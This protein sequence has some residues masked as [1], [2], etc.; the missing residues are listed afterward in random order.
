MGI[1]RP[2]CTPRWF[3][4][5]RTGW[6]CRCRGMH[7][8]GPPAMRQAALPLTWPARWAGL[9]A[10][11]WAYTQAGPGGSRARLEW[12]DTRTGG[13][14][15]GHTRWRA[16]G[17][18]YLIVAAV[19]LLAGTIETL[20]TPARTPLSLADLL[21]G[22][23]LHLLLTL[24][25]TALLRLLFWRAHPLRFIALAFGGALLLELGVVL[26]YWLNLVLGVPPIATLS[27]K[28]LTLLL[29]IAGAFVALLLAGLFAR[30][31]HL[32]DAA[33]EE[34]PG[35][36]GS[37]PR[38]KSPAGTALRGSRAGLVLASI[39]LLGNLALVLHAIPRGG[40]DDLPPEVA[41]LER[42]D[43]IVVLIDT[44]RRDHLS[45]YEYDRPT[46]PRIDALLADSYAFRQ[47]YTPSN[48]TV[49]S[50]A[51]I[52]TGLYPTSHGVYGHYLTVPE[53]A[54]TLAEAFRAHGYATG[55]FIDNPA[56]SE[57][58][59]FDQGFAVFYP[60]WAPWWGRSE[61]TFL[62]RLARGHAERRTHASWTRSNGP[63]VN[64]R[65]FEWVDARTGGG[66]DA[67][68][69]AS[70]SPS[71]EGG[72]DGA[73][74]GRRPIFGYVHYM[75][76]HHPY[77]PPRALRESV[78][79]D[80]PSG[81]DRTPHLLRYL[82]DPQCRDWQCLEDP[83]RMGKAELTGMVANY[84]GDVRW[85]DEL[86]GELLDGLRARG[87]LDRCHLLLFSDHGE[88]FFDH[89]GWRHTYS[90]YEEVSGCV[91][92][93]RP[94][95]GLGDAGPVIERPVAALDLGRTLF[96]I[97]GF[98]PP[99]QHQGR[100]IPELLAGDRPPMR[101][102]VLC[103]LPPHLFSLRLGPWKLLQRGRL[104]APN[105]HLFHLPSDP[106]EQ[107]DLAAAHPDTLQM[108]R[109]YLEGLRAEL[110]QISLGEREAITDP[111]ALERLRAL[112]YL[113]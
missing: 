17:A 20:A 96:E 27:G 19:A 90:I 101:Q 24:L 74:I 38:E 62:E 68:A 48:W 88:E 98:E 63:L 81:P 86:L 12:T 93:Y 106:Q 11:A 14:A 91:L 58:N 99:P 80:A 70:D 110:R 102:P 37:R 21:Y 69:G 15:V 79:P 6:Q 30:L 72:E 105:F 112:G 28:L 32:P 23:D 39:I 77:R 73:A 7:C 29:M 97:L 65:F 18:A 4:P 16:F 103:E 31:E 87:L 67:Q 109:G 94:P 53:R 3:R 2:P 50:V 95:G 49:P 42:P 5:R 82:D 64:A 47:A 8:G 75:E 46:T 51:S 83:P 104:E 55:A 22:V 108:L 40:K 9:C 34:A 41:A 89:Q 107:T 66:E 56:I 43:V 113:Q 61:R 33:C 60:G 57:A 35:G 59:Q 76:P 111:E 10:H 13:M 85:A 54:L 25:V 78:A 84:D 45:F 44:L 36:N 1:S 26:V 52:F 71:T 100:T 92:A